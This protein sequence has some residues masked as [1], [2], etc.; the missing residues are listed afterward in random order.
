MWGE[1]Y[2]VRG[3]SSREKYV[4][5]V[6]GGHCT[7]LAREQICTGMVAFTMPLAFFDVSF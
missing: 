6:S 2:D 3:G 1:I 7:L 5:V 4:E